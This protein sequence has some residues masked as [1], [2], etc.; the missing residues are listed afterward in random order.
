LVADSVN[1]KG[2]GCPS[3]ERRSRDWATAPQNRVS[4]VLREQDVP[5]EHTVTPFERSGRAGG[6]RVR[7][8]TKVDR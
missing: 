3:V 4:N 1:P 7:K 8:W 6:P 2:C 5:L